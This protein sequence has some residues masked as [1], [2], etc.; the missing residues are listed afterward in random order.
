VSLPVLQ[1]SEVI[2]VSF[3]RVR[4]CQMS[5]EEVEALRQQMAELEAKAIAATGRPWGWIHRVDT[6]EMALV[7]LNGP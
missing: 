6:D 2:G 4:L 5:R 7:R 3:P 1:K